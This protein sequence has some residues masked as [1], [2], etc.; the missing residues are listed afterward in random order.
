MRPTERDSSGFTLVEMLVG[1]AL[2]GGLLLR[3]P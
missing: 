2:G 1:M 3:K